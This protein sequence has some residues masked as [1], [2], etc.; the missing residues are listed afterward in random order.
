M[1]SPMPRWAPVTSTI[2]PRH[3]WSVFM[4][5]TL[6]DIPPGGR[7]PR[8][9]AW[10]GRDRGGLRDR[11]FLAGAVPWRRPDSRSHSRHPWCGHPPSASRR[12]PGPVACRPVPS[13]VT[14]LAMMSSTSFSFG[15]RCT[16]AG[17]VFGVSPQRPPLIRRSFLTGTFCSS[18]WGVSFMAASGPLAWQGSFHG[19]ASWH[20]SP[21]VWI[22]R[23]GSRVFTGRRPDGLPA[24]GQTA[25][26][27]PPPSRA[28]AR[29][30]R[31]GD[32]GVARR[33]RCLRRQRPRRA[34]GGAR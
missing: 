13:F 15:M 6:Y 19:P 16:A 8:E 24:I 33:M 17:T 29:S 32:L 30:L 7:R 22:S 25:R 20:L 10:S 12:D 3:R 21:N 2:F 23:G 34:K 9:A 14:D 26:L 18:R 1:A 31:F 28:S 5:D 27:R 4:V 11:D